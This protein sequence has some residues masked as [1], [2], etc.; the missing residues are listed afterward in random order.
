MAKFSPQVSIILPVYNGDKF[1]A[2]AIESCL[3]QKY[4]DFE[5]IIVNDCSSDNSLAIAQSF[6]NR[7]S[8]IKI[9]NNST[10]LKLP[11]SLNKGH[12]IAEGKFLTWTSHD[13]LLNENYLKLLIKNIVESKAD[14]IFSNFDIIWEDGT[15][16][17]TNIAGPIQS[18][19]FGDV[20][21]ASFLYRKEVFTSLKGYQDN[22]YLV[23]DYDFFLRASTKFKFFHLDQVLYKYRIQSKSLTASISSKM[24]FA[25]LHQHALKNMYENVGSIFN[26]NKNTVEFL[27]QQY[28][29]K[30]FSMQ[31]YLKHRKTIK[32][33]ISNYFCHLKINSSHQNINFLYIKIFW[34][35]YETK[36]DHTISILVESIL[37]EPKII[38]NSK[39]NRNA[40]IQMFLDCFLSLKL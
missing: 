38:F 16:K 12:N 30:D 32:K 26:F 27:V 28:F 17:R 21:G 34:K 19:I 4:E 1:L 23:E 18:L 6:A 5:L 10:N 25:N 22:L 37:K 36:K 7:D 15:Y 31:F 9:I 35:W 14:L 29:K 11:K 13:N 39:N 24:H 8:R 33:D 40:V 3:A 2:S 20:V